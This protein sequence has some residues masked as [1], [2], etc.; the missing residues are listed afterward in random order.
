MGLSA[1]EREAVAGREGGNP[2]GH[3]GSCGAHKF[4]EASGTSPLQRFNSCSAL[5]E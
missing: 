1:C 2:P 3:L 4:A 5:R